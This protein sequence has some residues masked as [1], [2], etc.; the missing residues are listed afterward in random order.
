MEKLHIL[1][2]SKTPEILLDPAGH[3]KIKGRAIDE[4]RSGVPEQMITWIDEY[5]RKPSDSTDVTIALE[6]L[7]SFNTLIV[8]NV[9]KKISQLLENHRKLHVKWYYEEDDVDIYDRGA[10]ISSVLNIPIEFIISDNVSE[11]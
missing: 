2:T 8:T 6:F 11:C 1:P 10:Y 9:L 5:V 7:N 3:I 4:S